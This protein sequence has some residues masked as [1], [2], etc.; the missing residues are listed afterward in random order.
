MQPDGGYQ[1][2]SESEREATTGWWAIAIHMNGHPKPF[3]SSIINHQSRSDVTTDHGYDDET[4]VDQRFCP[5]HNFPSN[6]LTKIIIGKLRAQTKKNGRQHKETKYEELK[7]K[8]YMFFQVLQRNK[9]RS[10]RSRRKLQR[11]S[12]IKWTEQKKKSDKKKELTKKREGTRRDRGGGET[13]TYQVG[14]TPS[15]TSSSRRT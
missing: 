14:Y 5:N 4:P 2:E 7:R 1:H 3:Q 9:S 15:P 11:S 6:K 12:K 8:N 10:R 13:K